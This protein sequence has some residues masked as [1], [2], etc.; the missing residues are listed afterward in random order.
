MTKGPYTQVHMSTTIAL[1]SLLRKVKRECKRN[2]RWHGGNRGS[3][4]E[5]AEDGYD[6]YLFCKCMK[7]YKN[8]K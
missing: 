5:G 3:W 4:S 7:C 8:K 6:Q 2:G 1:R